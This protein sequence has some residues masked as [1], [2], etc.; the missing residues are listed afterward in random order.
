MR[1]Q[2]LG[3]LRVPALLHGGHRVKPE[4]TTCY[5]FGVLNGGAWH[6]LVVLVARIVTD[7]EGNDR[8]SNA[9]REGSSRL[10]L[11]IRLVCPLVESHIRPILHATQLLIR[12]LLTRA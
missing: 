8:L 6:I 10:R 4:R 7:A 9:F 3:V 11:M 5:R 1:L 12:L 2:R